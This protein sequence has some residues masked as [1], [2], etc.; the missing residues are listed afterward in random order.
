MNHL[1]EI[2]KKK[3]VQ[4]IIYIFFPEKESEW[5]ELIK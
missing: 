4:H 5:S 2:N 3:Q 1:K